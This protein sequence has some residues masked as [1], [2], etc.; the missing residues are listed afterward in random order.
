MIAA[1]PLAT[2]G[3]RPLAQIMWRG[4]RRSAD[5]ACAA[6]PPKRRRADTGTQQELYVEKLDSQQLQTW[7]EAILLGGETRSKAGRGKQLSLLASVHDAAIHR[8]G[9]VFFEPAFV[10]KH[11]SLAQCFRAA[12]QRRDSQWQEVEASGGG[13]QCIGS[14]QDCQALLRKVRRLKE[15]AGV[16]ASFLR[17]R[18]ASSKLPAASTGNVKPGPLAA[19]PARRRWHL[20]GTP[21][22]AP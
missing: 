16:H 7:T 3:P 12:I 22:T 13:S 10:R 14:L 11:K 18:C 6:P 20:A 21:V 17:P 4:L 2:P 1:P 8:A 15:V 9:K 19:I 5:E